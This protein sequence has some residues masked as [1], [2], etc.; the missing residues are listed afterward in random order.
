MTAYL[1]ICRGQVFIMDNFSFTVSKP[2]RYIAFSGWLVTIFW[3]SL[4]P[5][6]PALETNIFGWDKLLHAAAYGCLT[7]IG[8]WALAGSAPLK[9][10]RWA[11][12][13]GAA[14][15]FGIIMELLQKVCTETRTAE[16]W[17]LLANGVGAGVVLL[18]VLLVEAYKHRHSERDGN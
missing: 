2:L 18:G 16:I 8:G 13:A 6:P 17:D 12:I 10:N 15:F 3:L 5:A 4:V 14:F 1:A 7:G 9:R 11:M